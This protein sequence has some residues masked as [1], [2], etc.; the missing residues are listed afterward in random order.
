MAFVLMVQVAID[1][2]I[3]VAAV[4]DGFVAASRPVNMASLMSSAGV[5]GSAGIG[6]VRADFDHMLV[7]VVAVGRVQ[8]A[9]VQVVD[10]IAVEDGGV[11]AS[12]SVHMG[13]ISM[14]AMFTHCGFPLRFLV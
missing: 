11:A 3:D 9:V 13:M 6:V 14:N 1:Q 4:G 10:M 8:V 5:A 12:L 7:E 2:V